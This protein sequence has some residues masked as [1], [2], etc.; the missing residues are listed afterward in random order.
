MKSINQNGNRNQASLGNKSPNVMGN[1]NKIQLS[2]KQKIGWFVG[3]ILFPV[4]SGL[5]VEI[6]KQGKVSELFGFII[7]IFK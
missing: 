1:H 7:N 4:I 3:G 2:T 6:I 5:I